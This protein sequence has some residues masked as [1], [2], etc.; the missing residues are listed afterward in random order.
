MAAVLVVDRVLV[1]DS[2]VSLS[3]CDFGG[4]VGTTTRLVGGAFSF[5]GRTWCALLARRLRV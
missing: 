1:G 5:V 3:F 4:L 2:L